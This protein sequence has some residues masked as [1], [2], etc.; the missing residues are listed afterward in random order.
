MDRPI[1]D[2]LDG[3]DDEY[4]TELLATA[5]EVSSQGKC[6]RELIEQTVLELCDESYLT[7]GV[8]AQLLGRSEDY[9]RK[10]VLNPLVAAKRLRR[11]F[12]SK[13]NDPRQAYTAS[14]GTAER[15]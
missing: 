14:T 2:S 12:P 3:L 9:L 6:S 8:F 1:V 7:L 15:A 13:P 4:R 5:H 10:D 11:A